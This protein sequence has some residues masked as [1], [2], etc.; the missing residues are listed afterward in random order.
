MYASPRTVGDVMTREVVA[1]S[2]GTP[3]K[4]IVATMRKWDVGALPV[5]TGD[6]RVVGMVSE[7]DLLHKEQ[8][9]DSDPGCYGSVHALSDIEKAAAA[10]AEELMTAPAACVHTGTTPAQA[11]RF[12]AQRKVKRLPVTDA[13]GV[14]RGIVSQRDLL[15][16]FLRADA[17]IAAEVRGEVVHA[18][19][20]DEPGMRV[21][22]HEGVVTLRG[23]V[24]EPR[25]IPVA[26]RLARAVQGVVDVHT[27]LTAEPAA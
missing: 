23:R 6:G 12:M 24:H 14:L 2:P 5:L 20:P 1:V 3:F 16:V 26:G 13:E 11:A 10:T 19:F 22:V 18:L 15:G 27:D 9:R 7:A 8:L 4:E 21:D 25:L 17:D